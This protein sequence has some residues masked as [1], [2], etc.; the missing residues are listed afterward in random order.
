MYLCYIDES[1]TPELS[2]NTSHF[3]LAGVSIPIANWRDTDDQIT[4]VLRKY[5]LGNAELH[6][7]WLL[8]AYPEQDK[9]TGFATLSRPARRTA[10]SQARRAE[11]LRL[12]KASKAKP[13]RQAKKNF[14]HTE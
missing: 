14:K 3:V 11:L 8:R 9:I 1:G 13:Y 2:A 12:Q 4:A 5:D 6:T 10:V 7:A